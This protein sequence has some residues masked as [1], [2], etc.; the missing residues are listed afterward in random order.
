MLYLDLILGPTRCPAGNPPPK[1]KCLSLF[2]SSHIHD[3]AP[4]RERPV[5]N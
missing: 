1:N 4:Q 3:H 5:L 2:R